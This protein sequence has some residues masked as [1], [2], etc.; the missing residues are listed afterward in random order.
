MYEQSKA[1]KRRFHEPKFA[2]TY[3]VGHG[4]DVGCGDDSLARSQ[5]MFP[6]IKSVTGWDLPDGDAQYLK[7][8]PDDH[9]DFVHSSH[10]LEH[11]VTWDIALRNWVRV[12]KPGG[13]IIVTI[14]DFVMYEHQNWPSKFNSDHK[15]IFTNDGRF[16]AEDSVDL[17]VVL[18]NFLWPFEDI[19]SVIKYE[20]IDQFYHPEIAK[21]Y[22]N[23]DQTLLPNAECCHEFVLRKHAR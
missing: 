16:K 6:L 19:A 9:F 14:P 2:T 22:P 3:F 17:V 8:V 23:L 13:Y 10:C 12:T 4:L 11:M 15:W 1:A 21:Q 18:P 7:S 20:Y 5:H